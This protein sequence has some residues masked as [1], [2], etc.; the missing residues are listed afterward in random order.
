MGEHGAAAVLHQPVHPGEIAGF[1][2]TVGVRALVGCAGRVRPGGA[3]PDLLGID[4]GFPLREQDL[5]VLVGQK[6]IQHILHAVGEIV[7]RLHAGSQVFSGVVVQPVPL[8]VLGDPGCGGDIVIEGVLFS[9][10]KGDGAF[11]VQRVYGVGA[12]GQGFLLGTGQGFP[13]DAEGNA[14]A[15]G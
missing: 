9:T 15:A 14:E 3:E 7:V 11:A 4:A 2:K 5:P 8:A 12:S 13:I 1:V 6:I 10:E